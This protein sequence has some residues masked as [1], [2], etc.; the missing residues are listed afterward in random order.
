[1][2]EVNIS[3]LKF[4]NFLKKKHGKDSDLAS[5]YAKSEKLEDSIYRLTSIRVKYFQ[6]FVAPKIK[7]EERCPRKRNRS[8][9]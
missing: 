7:G 9:M 6:E 4:P 2:S 3:T 1:M 8:C 5:T